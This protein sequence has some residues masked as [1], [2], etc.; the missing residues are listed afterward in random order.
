VVEREFIADLNTRTMLAKRAEIQRETILVVEDNLDIRALVTMF[1]QKAGYMVVTADNGEEGLV[2]FKRHQS[3]I[4]LLLTDVMMPAMNG[5]DLAEHILQLDSDLPVLFMS[6]GAPR[7]K[8]RFE[9]IKKPFNS[10]DLLGRVTQ[11][12]HASD[13]DRSK[14]ECFDHA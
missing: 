12:L 1:L 7:L 4:G 10:A 9:C 2:A 14:S 8:L 3:S 6:G 11:V 5:V 13:S